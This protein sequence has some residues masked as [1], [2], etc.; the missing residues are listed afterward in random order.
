MINAKR[1]RPD[2]GQGVEEKEAQHQFVTKNVKGGPGDKGGRGKRKGD[3]ARYT[4][5]INDAARERKVNIISCCSTYDDGG[6][7]KSL[8]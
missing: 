7:L 4:I 1:R 6:C 8:T 5:S 3:L 2:K